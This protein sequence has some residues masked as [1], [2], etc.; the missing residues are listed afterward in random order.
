MSS[1]VG[2]HMCR[3]AALGEAIIVSDLS[4]DSSFDYIAQPTANFISGAFSGFQSHTTHAYGREG[5][6]FQAPKS[7]VK[8]RVDLKGAKAGPENGCR[9]KSAPGDTQA[10]YA[11]DPDYT[12]VAVYSCFDNDAEFTKKENSGSGRLTGELAAFEPKGNGFKTC[13]A[14]AESSEV[15]RTKPS[16]ADAAPAPATA[17]VGSSRHT[18]VGVEGRDYP[19]RILKIGIDGFEKKSG[20]VKYARGLRDYAASASRRGAAVDHG[21]APAHARAPAPPA[22]Y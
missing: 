13:T 11:T 17:A 2:T 14:E 16:V 6:C 21:L 4:N 3:P 19:I 7:D 20:C 8:I 18:C 10:N 1:A 12:R 5:S 15:K 22:L 9:F